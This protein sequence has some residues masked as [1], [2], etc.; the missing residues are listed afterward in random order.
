MNTQLTFGTVRVKTSPARYGYAS[1]ER[2]V[3]GCAPRMLHNVM[4]FP[5]AL[6]GMNEHMGCQHDFMTPSGTM[7]RLLFSCN[8]FPVH[9]QG[10]LSGK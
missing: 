8:L 7:T 5:F 10:C 3:Q 2:F 9:I 4:I 1:A 6:I